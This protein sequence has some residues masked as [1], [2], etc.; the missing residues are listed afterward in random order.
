MK[1]HYFDQTAADADDMRL[2]MSIQQGYVPRTCLLGGQI[3]WSEVQAG[4]DPCAGCEGPRERCHGRLGAHRA[5]RILRPHSD[6]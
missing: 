2:S 1:P 4:R 6:P 5:L 3:V